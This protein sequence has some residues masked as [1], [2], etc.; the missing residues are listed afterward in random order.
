MYC[1]IVCI[2]LDN[3]PIV[4]LHVFSSAERNPILKVGTVIRLGI[5]LL[6]CFQG[7]A[8]WA[9]SSTTSTSDVS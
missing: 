3:T 8:G 9:V 4:P 5:F 2:V 1:K 7:R 6:L